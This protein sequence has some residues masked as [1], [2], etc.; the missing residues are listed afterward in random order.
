MRISLRRFARFAFEATGR[1][2]CEGFDDKIFSTTKFCPQMTAFASM[3]RLRVAC[4][5]RAH[6][7]H[8][9]IRQ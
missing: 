6:V 5:A 1:A 4:C 7:A 2:G 9:E 3:T 8:G